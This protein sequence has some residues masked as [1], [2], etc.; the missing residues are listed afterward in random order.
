MFV[1]TP[2]DSPFFLQIHLFWE[3]VP[4]HRI[5][6]LGTFE[7]HLVHI[8]KECSKHQIS[9]LPNVLPA[10]QWSC[11]GVEQG[12]FTGEPPALRLGSFQSGTPCAGAFSH[13]EPQV[14]FLP[15][16][17]SKAGSFGCQISVFRQEGMFCGGDLPVSGL[18]Y[19]RVSGLA[20]SKEPA[21]CCLLWKLFSLAAMLCRT[22]LLVGN[23]IVSPKSWAGKP[24]EGCWL[25][26]L[27]SG[28]SYLLDGR[29]EPNFSKTLKH[30]VDS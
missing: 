2:I 21:H 14:T 20:S 5:V 7:G 6:W 26:L 17:Y 24:K 12:Q 30:V 13:Q 9:F 23:L 15:S 18:G 28:M 1:K 10:K 4:Y 19:P 3:I 8:S 22:L 16:S 11:I 29:P 27:F 25:G